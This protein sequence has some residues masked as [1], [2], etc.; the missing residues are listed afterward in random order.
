MDDTHPAQPGYLQSGLNPSMHTMHFSTSMCTTNICQKAVSP[1]FL[2]DVI[3]NNYFH[4]T[5]TIGKD[6]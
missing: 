2:C 1:S 5:I 6:H 3:Q 4:R